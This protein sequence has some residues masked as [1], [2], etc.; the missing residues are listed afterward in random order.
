MADQSSVRQ[1]KKGRG[2]TPGPAASDDEVFTKAISSNSSSK[3]AKKKV[4][5]GHAATFSIVTALAFLTRF[6]KLSH[7]NEVVFDEVHFGKV[8]LY[9]LYR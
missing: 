5:F 9:I 1:R 2:T 6:Y 8:C 4:D 7:P 3:G